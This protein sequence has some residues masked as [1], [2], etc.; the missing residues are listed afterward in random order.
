MTNNSILEYS[1]GHEKNVRVNVRVNRAKN[2][3]N[4]PLGVN[5][6]RRFLADF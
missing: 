1:D 5:Q 6:V 3:K 4:A 2:A